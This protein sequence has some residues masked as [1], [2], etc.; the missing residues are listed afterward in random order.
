VRPE[1]VAGEGRVRVGAVTHEAAGRVRVQREQE[2]NEKVVGVVEGLVRLLAD[3][4]V[5]GRVH[6]E[7][8]QQHDVAGDAAGLGVVDL[9]RGLGA[10]LRALDIVEAGSLVLIE[11]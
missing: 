11:E 5:R 4:R 10:D 2:R 9:D 8:A 6:E 7:H 3:L 1:A